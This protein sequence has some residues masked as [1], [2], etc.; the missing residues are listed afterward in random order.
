MDFLVSSPI[1]QLH[2]S[3]GELVFE[4]SALKESLELVEHHVEAAGKRILRAPCD[5]RG[6]DGVG[7]R[8]QRV[9]L[10][11]RLGIKDVKPGNDL[12]LLQLFD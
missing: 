2:Q 12:F 3:G 1:S 8:A 5:V 6:E 10:R 4:W 9:V 11:Q 7:K